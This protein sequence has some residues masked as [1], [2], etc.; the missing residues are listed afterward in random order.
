MWCCQRKEKIK[1]ESRYANEQGSLYIDND[2][3]WTLGNVR[4]LYCVKSLY[5]LRCSSGGRFVPVDQDILFICHKSFTEFQADYN[6]YDMAVKAAMLDSWPS[7]SAE[8]RKY[9]N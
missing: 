9:K 8:P 7:S 1:V 6:K 2:A 5:C 4:S 3:K